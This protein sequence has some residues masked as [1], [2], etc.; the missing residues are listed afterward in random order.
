[1]LQVT[2][3]EENRYERGKVHQIVTKLSPCRSH[4]G[5]GN[6]PLG[7]FSIVTRG[8]FHEA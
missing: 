2:L 4:A 6:P 8:T 3:I 5:L 7:S 1:V